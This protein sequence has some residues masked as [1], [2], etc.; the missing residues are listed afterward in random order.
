MLIEMKLCV[1]FINLE[2]KFN[3]IFIV[4]GIMLFKKIFN[5]FDLVI[6]NGV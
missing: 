6:G 2:S 3:W 5:R 4:Y 1:I